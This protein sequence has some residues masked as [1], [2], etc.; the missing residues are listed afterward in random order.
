VMDIDEDFNPEMG[1][2][3]RTGLRVHDFTFH[4]TPYPG[5]DWVRNLNPHF[6]VTY[7][8][9]R[10]GRPVA[11]NVHFHYDMT[12]RRGERVG[13]AYNRNFELLDLPFEM[14]PGAIVPAGPHRFNELDFTASSDASRSLLGSVRFT[15]GELYDGDFWR[16]TARTLVRAGPR[17]SAQLSWT[18]NDIGLV[19]GAFVTDLMR[20]RV[21]YDFNPRLA[22]SGLLQ[23]NSRA[24]QFL[25][26]FRLNFIHTPGA[27]FFLVYNERL[28][29]NPL[30]GR[31][32]F[33]DRAVIAKV[34]HL[35]RF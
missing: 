9:D 7:D 14:Y 15:R 12:F 25:S 24:E 21:N 17:M 26:N 10:T 22:F 5:A 35:I 20:L 29:T 1:F 13:V 33:I 18:R 3:N 8:T 19:S 27:D 30:D 23:Y 31:S 16:F 34:T 4:Y 32:G 6:A 28:L 11:R 2:V